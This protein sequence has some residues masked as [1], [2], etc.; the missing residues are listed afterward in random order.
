M[1]DEKTPGNEQ[2]GEA[3]TRPSLRNPYTD[4]IVAKLAEEAKTKLLGGRSSAPLIQDFT[5]L[6]A[7]IQ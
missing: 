5:H 7:D 2:A 6:T 1:E 3:K 4:N